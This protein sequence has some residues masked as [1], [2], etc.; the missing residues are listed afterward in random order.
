MLCS[1][2]FRWRIIFPPFPFLQHPPNLSFP[3]FDCDAQI[4]SHVQNY[5]P[6]LGRESLLEG[7][8]QQQKREGGCTCR[9]FAVYMT[10]I[11]VLFMAGFNV[12]YLIVLRKEVVRRN[13]LYVDF[14]MSELRHNVPY[15]LHCYFPFMQENNNQNEPSYLV[16]LKFAKGAVTNYYAQSY[17]PDTWKLITAYMV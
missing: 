15:P 2:Q 14:R 8:T 10:F 16:N 5:E 6:M 7:S 17:I 13:L 11:L 12:F 4:S 9:S 1:K 3:A